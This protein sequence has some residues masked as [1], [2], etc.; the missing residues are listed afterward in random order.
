MKS[1]KYLFKP[2]G[3]SAFHVQAQDGRSLCGLDLSD[4]MKKRS[5]SICPSCRKVAKAKGIQVPE[6]LIGGYP[7]GSPRGNAL[8]CE[9]AAAAIARI[10]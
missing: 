7:I 4:G 5:G 10:P 3:S 8:L 2:F 6:V 9:A 1:P